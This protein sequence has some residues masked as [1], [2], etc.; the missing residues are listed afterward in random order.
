MYP[1]EAYP[2]SGIFV[3]EQVK[4]LR[5][6]GLDVR[7]LTGFSIGFSFRKFNLTF[8]NL[9]QWWTF[10]IEKWEQYDSVP[11]I[12]VP[13]LVCFLLTLYTSS[14][15]YVLSVMRYHKRLKK[16]FSFDII[17]AHTSLLDGN[18][19]RSLAKRYKVPYLITEHTGPF[20]YLTSNVFLKNRTNKAIK[21][22]NQL[23]A[24][25]HFMLSEMIKETQLPL[26]KKAKIIPNLVDI[27]QYYLL[28]KK[29]LSQAEINILWVGHFVSIKQLNKLIIA[30]QQ[31]LNRYQNRTIRLN[32]VGYGEDEVSI[33]NLVRQLK[34]EQHVCFWGRANRQELNA[35]YNNCDFL[36]VSSKVETFSVVTIEAM[37]CGLPVLSTRCG[38]PQSIIVK[39][40]LGLLVDQTE[41]ALTDG[42]QKM[43]E[44]LPNFDRNEIRN[45]IVENFSIDVVCEKLH[46]EYA[47]LASS[48]L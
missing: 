8:K 42:M 17:H 33:K 28:E 29:P 24:V 21:N 4:G 41:E 23:I 46:E 35:Y 1:N 9:K 48:S 16:I 15:S 27:H 18:V 36:V 11:V 34:L 14:F 20:S 10:N 12:R 5:A 2:T 22:A 45:Y 43:I 32:L 44:N 47:N 25:S 39:N 37:S 7:V 19:A 26:E 38:G 6:K 40:E 13:F 31:L 3:H 30:F